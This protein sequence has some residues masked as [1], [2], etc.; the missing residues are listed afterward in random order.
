MENSMKARSLSL[1]NLQKQEA[2]CWNLY[3]SKKP[4]VEISTKAWSLSL[5]SLR[6]HK[7]CCWNLY[8]SKKPFLTF[9][10]PPVD[11]FLNFCHPGRVCISWCVQ[12]HKEITRTKVKT[13]CIN[14]GQMKEKHILRQFVFVPVPLIS[15][16]I[17][18]VIDCINHNQ[19]GLFAGCH[20]L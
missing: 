7:A 5:G 14:Y 2:F 20:K 16:F 9:C 8:E 12:N 3:E 17:N 6:K 11:R 4:F 10:A 18:L 13:L 1:R 15:S 19:N